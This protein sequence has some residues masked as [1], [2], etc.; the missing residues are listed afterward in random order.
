V[1]SIS[2]FLFLDIM[3]YPIIVFNFFILSMFAKI[4]RRCLRP[5]F[6]IRSFSTAGQSSGESRIETLL[7]DKLKATHVKIEDTSGIDFLNSIPQ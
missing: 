7:K 6:C 1:F 5:Q 4:A 2:N 3:G